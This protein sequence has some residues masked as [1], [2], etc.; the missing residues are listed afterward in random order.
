MK[1]IKTL[2]V[3]MILLI[4]LVSREQGFSP[5]LQDR[6]QHIID[7]FQNDPGHPFIGGMSVAIKVDGLALWQ[8]ATGFAARNVDAQNNLLPGGTPFT[9]HTL[10]RI[11]SVT[12]TFT[13][14]LVMELEKQGVFKLDDSVGMYLPTQC[15]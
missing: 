13:A 1:S 15:N 11:Y 4:T 7:S 6:L 10:S 12:K 8:G 3:L 2:L 14:S 9:I 5:V